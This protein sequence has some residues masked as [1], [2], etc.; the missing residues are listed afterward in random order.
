M[1]DLLLQKAIGS[2]AD[3]RRNHEIIEK[4]YIPTIDYDRVN[5]ARE[6]IL[7]EIISFMDFK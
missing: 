2:L 3:A 6:K 7:E 1:Y 4:I 5:E